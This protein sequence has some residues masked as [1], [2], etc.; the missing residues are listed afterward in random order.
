MLGS[1][2]NTKIN[3]TQTLA[4]KKPTQQEKYLI[5]SNLRGQYL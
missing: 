3:K 4:S 1:I 5:K 2:R